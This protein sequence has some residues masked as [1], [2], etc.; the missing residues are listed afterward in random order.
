MNTNA[1]SRSRSKK[2]AVNDQQQFVWILP[3]A[4]YRWMWKPLGRYLEKERGLRPLMIVPSEQDRQFYIT[5]FDDPLEPDQVVLTSNYLDRVVEGKCRDQQSLLQQAT[6]YEN[7][8]NITFMRDMVQCCRHHGRGFTVGWNG[9][10]K[11]RAGNASNLNAAIDACLE[12]VDYFNKLAELYPPRL[13]ISSSGCGI[14]SKSIPLLCREL[15]VPFRSLAEG[16]V[17]DLFYW[18]SDEFEN[19]LPFEQA[20]VKSP[21][22][23]ETKIQA[24]EERIKPNAAF[25]VYGPGLLRYHSFLYTTKDICYQL[26]HHTYMK[27][28]GF[29]KARFGF[30]GISTAWML[31][32]KCWETRRQSKKPFLGINDIPRDRK[33]VFL[34]LGNEPEVSVQGQSPEYSNQYAMLVDI[35]LS[36]PADALLVVKEHPLQLGRRNAEFY[37]RINEMPNACMAQVQLPSHPLIQRAHLVC[38]INGSAAYEAA[39]F[40]VPVAYFSRHG[41]IRAVPHVKAIKSFGDLA[42]IR[43]VLTRDSEKERDQRRQDGARFYYAS[44]SHC[45]DLD[46]FNFHTRDTAP[47][48]DEI[49]VIADPLLQNT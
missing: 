5:Q 19:S 31:L 36:I 23:E 46:G 20:I 32:R 38:T 45:M 10:P 8:H 22:V 9:W 15:G 29:R 28:R 34:P 21:N 30:T 33:I 12:S 49:K 6:E 16:R 25:R 17:N 14:F 41:P 11:S 43:E 18:A 7:R 13:V 35:A 1:K 24:M 37:R 2:S 4:E 40:G 48:S 47:S 39:M 44:N 42:W 3:V 26:I 27:L